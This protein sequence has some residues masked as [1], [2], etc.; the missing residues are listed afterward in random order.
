VNVALIRLR[1]K[2]KD[3]V[4]GFRVP[5]VPVVPA[6]A[7]ILQAIIG[8][9]LVQYS[10]VAFVAAAA[11]VLVGIGVHYGCA[12]RREARV[13]EERGIA[14]SLDRKDYRIL[15][16]LGSEEKMKPLVDAAV[17]IAAC[18]DGEIVGCSV[19]ELATQTP[20]ARGSDLPG[21]QASR[22]LLRL[23][24]H[25]AGEQDVAFR[26]VIKIAHRV[27]T[28]I[29]DTA[30]EERCNFI[31]IGQSP[32]AGFTGRLART[33]M[34]QVLRHPSC[35]VAVV[36]DF[37]RDVDVRS[38][39]VPAFAKDLPELPRIIV[40]TPA[41]VDR[42]ATSRDLPPRTEIVVATDAELARD[43]EGYIHPDDVLVMAR[44][45]VSS[46]VGVLWPEALPLADP[47]C[48]RLV[49]VRSYRALKRESVLLRLL[50]GR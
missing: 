50:T 36:K 17:R 2:R 20:L 7:M 8:A 19:V 1:T 42:I 46:V 14:E 38:A 10:P 44:P 28:A 33:L 16:A 4:R 5:W 47:P 34:E 41:W 35:H 26:R 11:W 31:V 24:E 30:R 9:Y 23:A 43:A 39:V 21:V 37:P 25:I 6:V 49:T 22:Q 18:S 40:P 45:D 3:L 32:R 27:S 15:L 13:I 12:S 29:A 48:R